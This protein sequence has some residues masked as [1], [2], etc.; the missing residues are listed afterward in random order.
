MRH[1]YN[2]NMTWFCNLAT[3]KTCEETHLYYA[4]LKSEFGITPLRAETCCW[5]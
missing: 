1:V 3:E 4:V 5:L 2:V